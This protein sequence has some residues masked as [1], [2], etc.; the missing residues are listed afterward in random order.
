M[1]KAILFTIFLATVNPKTQ[2]KFQEVP[3]LIEIVE[4]DVSSVI[5][6]PPLTTGKFCQQFILFQEHGFYSF[7]NTGKLVHSH[8]KE[9]RGPGEFELVSSTIV[10]NSKLYIYDN[11]QKKV[12]IFNCKK[13]VI[14]FESEVYLRTF[15]SRNFTVDKQENYYFM[16]S[17]TFSNSMSAISKFDSIGNKIGDFGVIPVRSALS[18]GLK[19]GGL[20]YLDG[21]GLYYSYMGEPTFFKID[22]L[23]N[24]ISEFLELPSYSIFASNN[25]VRSIQRNL[26][27]LIYTAYE[28][29][30]I[31]SVHNQHNHVI[32]VI[33]HGGARMKMDLIYY[34]DIWF[35][36]SR[37]KI[38]MVLPERFAFIDENYLY[39]YAS[40]ESD[41]I[42]SNLK[43][44]F[45]NKYKLKF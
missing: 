5:L 37:I 39:T 14:N 21:K 6:Q 24:E 1:N 7:S 23:T 38:E 20:T 15:N 33:E 44:S 12:S 31:I 4:L 40:K 27:D 19:G 25:T 29:S 28:N 26:T 18:R 42:S 3:E 13:E 41:L 8:I 45:F 34:L 30:R 10:N 43:T 9:G 16:N 22:E 36:D 32:R 17:H 35:N 2:A 11:S